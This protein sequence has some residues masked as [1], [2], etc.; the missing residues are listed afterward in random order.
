MI[1]MNDVNIFIATPCFD[2]K[3]NSS[4]VCTLLELSDLGIKFDPFFMHDSLIN[5]VRNE[6]ITKF[7]ENRDKYTHLL[8]LDSDVAPSANGLVKLLEKNVDVIAAAVP[9]KTKTFDGSQS[10]KKIFEEIGPYFYSVE[11]A[12]TGCLL[13]SKKSVIDLIKNSK[14]YHDGD[15]KIY[16][17][18][19][20]R[21]VDD[22]L[23][24]EDY[25]MCYKL[26]DLNYKI[27]VD[28]SF[29]VSH[30][31]IFEW[32]RNKSIHRNLLEYR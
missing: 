18:F 2:H 24:S 15:K 4:Y 29:E 22:I 3:V 26:R 28:S 12:S 25:D 23:L 13:M 17:V 1:K 27:Y 16:N 31:G 30:S 5:R 21:I 6:L 32:K 20:T 9:I 11:A 7:Y 10:V 14:F 19:E 8:W